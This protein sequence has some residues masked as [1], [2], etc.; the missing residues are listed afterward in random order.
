MDRDDRVKSMLM[1]EGGERNV[2]EISWLV[3]MLSDVV[4]LSNL[5]PRMLQ[6]VCKTMKVHDYPAGMAVYTSGDSANSLF[7]VLSG[8]AKSWIIP[9]QEMASR[10][11]RGAHRRSVAPIGSP[12]SPNQDRG[13]MAGPTAS[14]GENS[15]GGSPSYL[16]SNLSRAPRNVEE[17]LSTVNGPRAERSIEKLLSVGRK[18]RGSCIAWHGPGDCLGLAD[19]EYGKRR[20]QLR[21]EG[22]GATLIEIHRGSV[23]GYVA[24]MVAGFKH[25]FQHCT[26]T[27]Q[28]PRSLR[29]R[30]DVMLV[31]SML[32]CL[33]AMFMFRREQ[34]AALCERAVYRHLEPGEVA[35]LEGDAMNAFGVVMQGSLDLYHGGDLGVREAFGLQAG[36]V[37]A[38]DALESATLEHECVLLKMSDHVRP[39]PSSA[40]VVEDRQESWREFHVMVDSNG[41]VKILSLASTSVD[42]NEPAVLIGNLSTDLLRMQTIGFDLGKE[43][44]RVPPPRSKGFFKRASSHKHNILR[45]ASIG[46]AIGEVLSSPIA[47]AARAHVKPQIRLHFE[48]GEIH[49]FSAS[50]Q[51]DLRQF[52]ACVVRH[53][54][55]GKDHPL[56]QASKALESGDTFGEGSV[57]RVGRAQRDRAFA[58]S[59]SRHGGKSEDSHSFSYSAAARDSTA[60]LI[61]SWNDLNTVAMQSMAR[62]VLKIS[63]MLGHQG[64]YPD[65]V[66]T[67][68]ML[69]Q[70]GSL[71][72]T[73]SFKP[74]DFLYHAGE[75]AGELYF[76]LHGE[77]SLR[78]PSALQQDGDFA[79]IVVGDHSV[80]PMPVKRVNRG[81]YQDAVTPCT[82][83]APCVLGLHASFTKFEDELGQHLL[84][85]QA[86]TVVEAI[87][88]RLADLKTVD[89]DVR[90]AF[91]DRMQALAVE[92][93]KGNLAPPDAGVFP[94]SSI[95]DLSRLL[96]HDTFG[97]EA[98]TATKTAAKSM[99]SKSRSKQ[100]HAMNQPEPDAESAKWM[101]HGMP[102]GVEAQRNFA[103]ATYLGQQSFHACVHLADNVEEAVKRL[104]TRCWTKYDSAMAR[105]P[106][107]GKIPRAP[108]KSKLE[109][110]DHAQQTM[111]RLAQETSEKVTREELQPEPKFQKEQDFQNVDTMMSGFSVQ[112]FVSTRRESVGRMFEVELNLASVKLP[113]PAGPVSW[114]HRPP[115]SVAASPLLLKSISPAVGARGLHSPMVDDIRQK[116]GKQ[117]IP[118]LSARTN[119]SLLETVM[120]SSTF[121]A[122]I[123]SLGTPMN[124][125]GTP[126]N[127]A[128]TPINFAGTP[129]GGSPMAVDA[130]PGIAEE[131]RA[132]ERAGGGGAVRYARRSLP[133]DSLRAEARPPGSQ[134]ANKAPQVSAAHG[135]GWDGREARGLASKV[136]ALP[137]R[138]A[139]VMGVVHAQT[140][141][142]DIIGASQWVS[143]PERRSVTPFSNRN[144]TFL[145]SVPNRHAGRSK[146]RIS[147][148]PKTG[149]RK[150]L[151]SGIVT[152]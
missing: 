133:A 85:A 108:V 78:K 93:A 47:G 19:M 27:L 14:Y 142:D 13:S 128:R 68:E 18:Q 119:D 8:S 23:E 32:R 137:P 36:A 121:G 105:C 55:K 95:S 49:A 75:P 24:M 92:V 71:L 67:T 28:V 98:K 44:S 69:S 129:M 82:A 42:D 107:C 118:G 38:K 21:T 86:D 83:C 130:R 150:S 88:L 56:G 22:V 1:I 79:Y 50:A 135:L 151:E 54:L 149:L 126:M 4:P 40:E 138:P 70:I 146:L 35:F 66:N 91:G 45:R 26:H 97:M 127:G 144:V 131:E 104:C 61:L 25:G 143:K 113:K 74:T 17:L 15:P 64:M 39:A 72:E 65:V 112:D 31:E 37:V 6:E 134:G 140:L 103:A 122:A 114:A 2:D 60:L 16:G 96:P 20:S 63:Q 33:P 52:L 41:D 53:R 59:Q 12:I 58:R 136:L 148:P 100:L 139:T 80:Q 51:S 30:D 3:K 43:N 120:S 90:S 102:S 9:G 5:P 132:A 62:E 76:I 101:I 29:F 145:K 125:S 110:C 77:C 84:S 11:G 124:G 10:N 117:A 89:P 116:Y 141:D 109:M 48:R 81:R 46:A 7:V 73:R 87:V 34:V 115:Q 111:N 123:N 147:S 152:F 99:R 94:S 57:Q 106:A